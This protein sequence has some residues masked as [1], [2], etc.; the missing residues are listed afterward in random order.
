[1]SLRIEQDGRLRRITLAAPEKRNFLDAVACQDLLREL[2]DAAAD[3][4]VGG[5]LIDAEGPLFCSGI[6]TEAG[7]DLFTIGRRI[8]KPLVAA[9]Q[10]VAVSGGLGL[11]ANAHVV[12]AAQGSS[13]GLTDIR[14]G[15]WNEA[16][17]RAVAGAIGERRTRELS[18]TG[19]IFSTPDALAWG[20]VHMVAPA[21]E[22][23][24]RATEIATALANAN[25]HAIRAAL[26]GQ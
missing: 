2:R 14:E 15:I 12:V 17:Y 24:D 4:A 3:D 11:L 8:A 18:L 16:L 5:I 19:R 13:F 21:F 25:P 7:A 10:G 22:L 20:L 23:D 26:R 1:M 6:E 9:V